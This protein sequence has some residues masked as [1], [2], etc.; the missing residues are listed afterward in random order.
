[1][2]W[3]WHGLDSFIRFF[4]LGSRSASKTYQHFPFSPLRSTGSTKNRFVTVTNCSKGRQRIQSKSNLR[5]SYHVHVQKLEVKLFW[6]PCLTKWYLG[7]F[8]KKFGVT[9]LFFLASLSIDWKKYPCFWNAFLVQKKHLGTWSG[10]I[11]LSAYIYLYFIA[12]TLSMY[13]TNNKLQ[14]K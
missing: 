5:S 6:G 7:N 10:S 4:L 13:F 1:M 14:P 8:V 9:V 12:N 3:Q 2:F 11:L